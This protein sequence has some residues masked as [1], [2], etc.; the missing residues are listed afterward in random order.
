MGLHA[1]IIRHDNPVSSLCDPPFEKSWLRPWDCNITILFILPKLR[2]LPLSIGS[3]RKGVFEQHTSTSSETSFHFIHLSASK[4][5]LLSVLLYR[6]HLLENLG[7]TTAQE[8]QNY[9]SAHARC[10]KT[11][12]LKLPNNDYSKIANW[13]KTE[14][15]SFACFQK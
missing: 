15:D 6:N 11:S 5:V 1:T 3:L 8:C 10:S 14:Q 7:K 4:F 9:T 2:Y 12:L 13:P